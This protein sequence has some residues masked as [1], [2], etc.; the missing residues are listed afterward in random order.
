MHI[1]IYAYRCA[2]DRRTR[3]RIGSPPAA[4]STPVSAACLTQAVVVLVAV[5]SVQHMA[6]T[7]I[8]GRN[9]WRGQRLVQE[10]TTIGAGETWG[11]RLGMWVKTLLG[12]RRAMGKVCVRRR[13]R[14]GGQL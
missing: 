1:L 6:A 11:R 9:V 4:T 7:R 14:G 12:A 13:G 8:R 2:A 10:N 3:R 5:P